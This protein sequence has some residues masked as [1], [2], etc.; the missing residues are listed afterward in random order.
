MRYLQ[1]LL[2]ALCALV[3]PIQAVANPLWPLIPGEVREYV[4]P[5]YNPIALESVGQVEFL[6]VQAFAV[7]CCG[8]GPPVGRTLYREDPNGDV[9]Q[10]GTE[11]LNPDGSILKYKVFEPPLLRMPGSVQVGTSWRASW[12]EKVYQE[13]RPTSV[14]SVVQDVHVSALETI[15]VPAGTFTAYRVEHFAVSSQSA[16]VTKLHASEEE[17]FGSLDNLGLS[18]VAVFWYAEKVGW[19]GRDFGLPPIIRTHS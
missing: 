14:W 13:G 19:I 5:I 12:T 4:Q 15:E 3:F 1:P 11:S 10:L 9:Y 16:D 7:V 6:G 8:D 2:P 17:V 18:P